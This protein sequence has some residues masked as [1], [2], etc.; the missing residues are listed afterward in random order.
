MHSSCDLWICNENSSHCVEHNYSWALWESL[1]TLRIWLNSS[2]PCTWRENFDGFLAHSLHSAMSTNHPPRTSQLQQLQNHGNSILMLCKVSCTT[3]TR[4]IHVCPNQDKDWSYQGAESLLWRTLGSRVNHG[5][6][7]TP[8]LD[9]HMSMTTN[10]MLV[11][12]V[13]IFR[14]YFSLW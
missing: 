10:R 3:K 2:L 6:V 14:P 13:F 11:M 5:H 7:S 12:F 1:N 4:C 9:E 8:L